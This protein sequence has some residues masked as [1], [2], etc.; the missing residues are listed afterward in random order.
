MNYTENYH[1]PQ[2]E[3]TDRI[4]RTDFN[5]MCA[6]I[7]SGID[8]ARTEAAELPSAVGSYYGDGELSREIMVGFRP[9]FVIICGNAQNTSSGEGSGQGI[10]MA[11]G[12]VTAKMLTLTENGFRYEVTNAWLPFP[13]VNESGQ[14]Y[15]YIAFR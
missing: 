2:W 6:D 9:R 11:G 3:E 12:S 13:K 15:C 5:Q 4:M 10:I 1:L 7:E 14:P 8:M